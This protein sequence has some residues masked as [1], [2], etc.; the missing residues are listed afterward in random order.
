MVDVLPAHEE[1][2][3]RGRIHTKKAPGSLPSSGSNIKPRLDKFSLFPGP[4]PSKKSSSMIRPRSVGPERGKAKATHFKSHRSHRSMEDNYVPEEVAIVLPDTAL[5]DGTAAPNSAVKMFV[6]PS[7]ERGIGSGS[8]AKKISRQRRAT[9]SHSCSSSQQQGQQG[10][11]EQ[12]QSSTE[13]SSSDDDDDDNPETATTPIQAWSPVPT[14][15]SSTPPHES[16]SAAA[17]ALAR[18]RP[19]HPGLAA[20][21]PG[22]GGGGGGS[23]IGASSYGGDGASKHGVGSNMSWVMR[24]FGRRTRSVQIAPRPLS[25]SPTPLPAT[26]AAAAA[27]AAAA[28]VSPSSEQHCGEAGPPRAPF[29]GPLDLFPSTPSVFGASAFGDDDND[30]DEGGDEDAVPG[31]SVR[32]AARRAAP[33]AD[34]EE[35]GLPASR[36]S[37]HTVGRGA[38]VTEMKEPAAPATADVAVA[39]ALTYDTAEPAVI[40]NGIVLPCPPSEQEKAF[41]HKTGRAFLVTAGTLSFLIT[42]V[43]LW[44]FTLA[45]PYFFWFGAPSAFLLFYLVFHYFVVAVWGKDFSPDAHAEV[46]AAAAEA[47]FFPTVDVF[48]PVCREDIALLRNTWKNVRAMEYPRGFEVYVLDDGAQ[49]DVR[50]LAE[51][52]GFHYIRR[53]NR[54]EMKKAGNLRYAFARTSGEAVVIFDADFCPRFDFLLET[55]PYLLDPT[56]GILQTPQYFRFRKEQTWVEKGAGAIQEFFYRMVQMNQDRFHGSVCVGSCGVYR[57]SAVEPFGGVVAISHSEDMYTGYKM[58]EQGSKIKY[59]P[60]CLAM[61]TCPDEPRSF[62]M[63][64]YRWAMGSATLVSEKGFWSANLS[65]IHK[66]CFFNGLLYYIATALLLFLAPLP[67][68]LLLYIKADTV[69]WYYSGF[70]VPT[71]L[72]VTVAMPLWS[73]QPYG[74]PVHRVRVIQCYAHLYALKDSLLGQAAAWVPSGGGASRSS[75]KAYRSS[76][77]LMVT[78]TTVSTAAIIGG[79]AWRILEGY[80]WYHFVPAIALATGSFCLNMSS[81]A[82]V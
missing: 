18:S 81:L 61:G 34:V 51:S 35:G 79:S 12:Q 82:R 20:D 40:E 7:V 25:E 27:A 57:R 47:Q 53:D 58:T 21:T 22:G 66:V 9:A 42:S 60:L 63:Q 45:S 4:E 33:E 16:A 50:D 68:I 24:L 80:L 29:G 37:T 70:T 74:M 52:F 13:S 56:I 44:L 49:D 65:T 19:R 30:A 67:I 69:L 75:S 5:P 62:F 48:L 76:V 54:P 71:I 23:S 11:Q 46:V 2:S 14:E 17:A 6:F 72:M 55:T 64:Q 10:Q 39:K 15:R 3:Q 32:A 41:Y 59:L 73:K 31:P 26:A 43:G 38:R 77:L 1:T 28:E 36:V 8:V 78:W